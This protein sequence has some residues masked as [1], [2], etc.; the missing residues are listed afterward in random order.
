MTWY[1]IEACDSNMHQDLCNNIVLSGGNT[2]FEGF[3]QRLRKEVKD[4][5]TPGFKVDIHAGENR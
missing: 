2:L 4:L 1:S 5:A 3:Q